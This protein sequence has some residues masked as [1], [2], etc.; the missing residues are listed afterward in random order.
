VDSHG[1]KLNLNPLRWWYRHGCRFKVFTS[2]GL[3]LYSF[4]TPANQTQMKFKCTPTLEDYLVLFLPLTPGICMLA[5]TALSARP[6]WLM[7][8]IHVAH[9]VGSL[10]CG[11][12]S[13][14]LLNPHGLWLY[15][16]FQQSQWLFSH[17]TT[18]LLH[19]NIVCSGLLLLIVH[20]PSTSLILL[21]S[22]GSLI[23]L[24][25]GSISF[26]FPLIDGYF[27]CVGRVLILTVALT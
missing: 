27:H 26:G 22:I 6:C 18:G 25:A 10:S 13:T 14:R 16:S 11:L 21:R 3:V 23:L 24:L 1:F 7:F 8:S 4:I 9:T 15:I 2:H 12:L 5:S 17:T 20:D 19:R